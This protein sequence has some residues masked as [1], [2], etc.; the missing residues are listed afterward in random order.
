MMDVIQFFNSDVIKLFV[1]LLSVIT[2]VWL[3][4][5]YKPKQSNI[6]TIH[7]WYIGF[8]STFIIIE[9]IT[10]IVVGN[11]ESKNIMDYVSFAATLSSLILSV[12]AIFITVLS[13]NSL[14]KV[15]DTLQDLPDQVNRIVQESFGE[16]KT[17][18]DNVKKISDENKQSQ[19]QTIE[20]LERLL[21]EL[22]I[23]MSSEF[24]ANKQQMKELKESAFASKP[25]PSVTEDIERPELNDSMIKYM[26]QRTSYASLLLIYTADTYLKE[27]ISQ[28]ISLHVLS[29]SIGYSGDNSLHYYFYA[30]VVQNEA[31]ALV[32]YNT[33]DKDNTDAIL[34]KSI[35][36]KLQKSYTDYLNKFE[37]Y[38]SDTERIFSYI[39][40]LKDS[41]GDDEQR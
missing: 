15:R 22:D 26:L 19:E 41:E 29:E 7:L 32:S 36:S 18:S 21:K 37:D 40:T 38:K 10:Y 27:N 20:K 23:H 34:F 6:R 11:P 8:I 25:L 1:I 28:P 24:A 5:Y 14:S 39:N 35:N 13:N 31:L 4:L 9:L 12:L 30:L 16:L 33:I 17:A 3:C 2:I